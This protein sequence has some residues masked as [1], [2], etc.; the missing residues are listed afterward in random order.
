MAAGK[1]SRAFTIKNTG[2]GSV[3]IEKIYTSCMCTAAKLTHN[4]KQF[5]PYG[6]PGHGV[7]PRISESLATNDEA[8][9]EVVF[10]PAAHGPSG[11]GRIDRVVVI[12]NSAGEPLELAIRATVTP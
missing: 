11:V 6:M 9:V 2:T 4:D 7:I 1:V 5:G 10:D 8:T 3:M 12:E